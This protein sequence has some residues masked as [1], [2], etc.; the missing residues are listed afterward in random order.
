M[1]RKNQTGHP[2]NNGTAGAGDQKREFS[3]SRQMIPIANNVSDLFS[4]TG[5]TPDFVYRNDNDTT[6]IIPSIKKYQKS[7]GSSDEN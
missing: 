6:L 1:M 5:E 4:Y 3:R 2:N 7:S